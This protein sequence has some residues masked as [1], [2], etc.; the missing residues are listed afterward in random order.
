MLKIIIPLAGSSELFQK[1][2]FPYP[3]PLID[4]KGKPMIEWVIESTKSIGISTQIIFIIKEEDSR[5]YHLD[6]TLKL[7][8]SNCEIVKLKNNTKGGL[9]SVLMSIDAIEDDDSILIL[10]SDQIIDENLSLIHDFWEQKK[11]DVGVVTFKSVHPRW[12]YAL[13]EEDDIIQTAEKNPISNQ[14]I[15]GYYYFNSAKLFFECAFQ[16]IINDVQT[17]GMF[18]ISPVINEFILRNKK[19]H[20]YQITNEQYHSFYSPKLVTEFESKK[21]GIREI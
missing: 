7:L 2:G 14:A 17:D 8:D 3:K 12:S 18:Y 5:A 6:N 9:C 13:T 1:A 4:I 16:T 19:V 15:A 21:D 11:S 10:N 20:Y